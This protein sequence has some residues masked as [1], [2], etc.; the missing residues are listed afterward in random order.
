MH[1]HIIKIIKVAIALLAVMVCCE[2]ISIQ[3]SQLFPSHDT[4]IAD[5]RNRIVSTLDIKKEVRLAAQK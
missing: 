5:Y 4:E 3:K 2:M 1:K